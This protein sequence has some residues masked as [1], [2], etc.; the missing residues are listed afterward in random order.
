MSM[1]MFDS[2]IKVDYRRLLS[3]TG[4][5]SDQEG[6]PPDLG[7]YEDEESQ[8]LRNQ[9]EDAVNPDW[10]CPAWCD[11]LPSLSLRERVL[12]CATCMVCGYILGFGSLLRMQQLLFGNPTPLVVNVTVGNI[13]A[14][15]G[16]CF[17][18]GPQQQ[19]HRMFHKSRKWASVCYLGA[20]AA[21]LL[22]VLLPAFPTRGFWL[23]ILL[24]GQYTACTWY[25]LSYI[26]F[27]RDFI[28]RCCQRIMNRDEFDG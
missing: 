25:C 22:L 28:K 16:T 9:Y 14:L 7:I 11:N 19:Y 10:R 21:S 17:L 2:V 8:A 6:P 5:S 27:A 15:C 13:L 1:S 20:M 24:I 4:G 12:G 26:P 18:S 23:C 3:A